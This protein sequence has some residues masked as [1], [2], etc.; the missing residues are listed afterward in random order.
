MGNEGA[1]FNDKVYGVISQNHMERRRSC[2]A[3]SGDIAYIKLNFVSLR[4]NSKIAIQSITNKAVRKEVLNY[5]V[6]YY[7]K[8][9][10]NN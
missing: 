8:L 9:T 3:W 1:I 4:V 2:G 6:K 5:K 7:F 10:T